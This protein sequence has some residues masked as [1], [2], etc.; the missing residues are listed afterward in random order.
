MGLPVKRSRKAQES[1]SEFEDFDDDMDSQDLTVSADF[2]FHFLLQSSLAL[3]TILHG[4]F[5]LFP[6]SFSG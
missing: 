6:F 2:F 4:F 1:D 5:S 3:I